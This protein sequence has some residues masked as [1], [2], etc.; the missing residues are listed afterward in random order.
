MRLK[1]LTK[2]SAKHHMLTMVGFILATQKDDG[3]IPWFQHGKLD[4]WDHAEAL[5]ALNICGEF[6]AVKRGF[7]WLSQNQNADGSW[8]AQY[9]GDVTH[10]DCHKIDTNFVAYPATALW[11]NYLCTHDTSLLDQYFPVVKSAIDYILTLQ[12]SDGDFQW[13]KSDKETLPHDALLTGNSSIL[14]SLECA[15]FSA[16][17]LGQDTSE[18]ESS[19]F[20][21]KNCLQTK[22]WRFDRTWESK[23]R[24]SMDWFY[25]ILSGALSKEEAK[26]RLEQGWQKF[27]I[28][29]LGCKCVED[30]P[31]VTVAESCELAISLVAS[32]RRSD[33]VKILSGLFQWQDKD[34]GLWTGYQYR[35]NTVWP[36]EKTTWTAG[37][38]T[39]ALDALF[40]FSPACKLFT[41]E[42]SLVIN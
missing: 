27:V 10:L 6:D 24:F 23:A 2:A 5:M 35:D 15:I 39:L 8:F 3:A 33:A 26:L 9:F 20:E 34:G 32:G 19:Y 30:E 40:E 28:D 11:H 36:K 1:T 41:S 29:D 13:A 25:P 38:A 17:T 42:S 31:W 18:W 37:A 12:T 4:P 21:L 7:D 14:R 16:E 22:P